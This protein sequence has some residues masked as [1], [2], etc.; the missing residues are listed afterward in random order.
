MGQS[1]WCRGKFM[2]HVSKARDVPRDEAIRHLSG[3]KI[4]CNAT[5]VK[6]CSLNTI[7]LRDLVRA[8]MKKKALVDLSLLA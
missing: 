4:T 1:S 6:K 8:M 7:L 5:N 2:C 3:G